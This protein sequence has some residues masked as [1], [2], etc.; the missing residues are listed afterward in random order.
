MVTQQKR[1]GP[2]LRALLAPARM[3]RVRVQPILL[4]DDIGQRLQGERLLRIL[5]DQ[6]HQSHRCLV[7]T[8]DDALALDLIRGLEISR[9]RPLKFLEQRLV[10]LRGRSLL[11]LP[12]D[13]SRREQPGKSQDQNHDVS[14]NSAW[15][16]SHISNHTA[17]RVDFFSALRPVPAPASW[18]HSARK[19]RG[20]STA[21]QRRLECWRCRRRWLRGAS[22]TLLSRSL[23]GSSTV[24]IAWSRSPPE[25]SGNLLGL[26]SAGGCVRSL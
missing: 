7:H 5:L 1:D 20:L 24:S 10:L 18:V 9:G 23:P 6:L 4:R 15:T 11:V 3:R 16:R 22:S 14:S 17:S 2:G 21:R 12:I 19:R 25:G 13:L 26:P 8:L